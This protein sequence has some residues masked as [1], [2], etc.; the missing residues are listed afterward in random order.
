MQQRGKNTTITE[1]LLGNG[2]FSWGFPEAV[3]WEELRESLESVSE[4]ERE[5]MEMR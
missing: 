5:E 2:A 4:N 1:E 3:K